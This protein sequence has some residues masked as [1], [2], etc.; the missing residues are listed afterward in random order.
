MPDAAASLSWSLQVT[1]L[2]TGLYEVLDPQKLCWKTP[3][4]C[5]NADQV[6]YS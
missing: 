1:E 3:E 6:I 4:F 2:Q 5:N